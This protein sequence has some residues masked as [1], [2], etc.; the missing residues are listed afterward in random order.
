MTAVFKRLIL[1][2]LCALF[3]CAATAAQVPPPTLAA[4]SW[5]LYDQTTSQF[6]VTEKGDERLEPASLTKLM[7][8]YIVFGAL[9]EGKIK[10]DQQVDV[11]EHAWKQEG[12]RMFIKPG[13]PVTVEQLIRGM[14]IQSGN[15]ACVALAE[16]VAGTEEAF[17]HLM[18]E[19]AKRL[20][21]ENTHYTNAN[22]LPDPQLYTTAKDLA[23]LAAAIIRDFP[24][25]YKY[26]SEKSFT[27]NKITQPNRN[28]LL[29]RD[30]TVD[31]MKTGHTNS[32]GYCL[33]AS[34]NR[35]NHRMISV[36][37]G[38]SSENVRAQES[39]K[40]LNYGFQFYEAAK[41]YDAEQVLARFQ[42]WKGATNEVAAGFEKPLILALPKGE[43]GK[44][45]P[46][47]TSVQP[48]LAPIRKGQE[49]GTLTLSLDGKDIGSWPVVALNE[50]ELAG[51]FGR[52]WDSL[53]MWFKS[54]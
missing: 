18:N 31:G 43:A 46:R 44:L 49:I 40:L 32:A 39:L 34:A 28:L 33:V 27:Y 53:I 52:T 14:I 24:E 42:V 13:M 45:Q 48:V 19:S 11:S 22:G 6:L 37:L 23:K 7:T 12:S 20:G 9:K 41:V 3:S 51:W 30:A 2:T 26:Y 54:L 16:L 38:S 10:L 35:N 5:V 17:V 1:A 50:V 8:A 47:L 25:G 4:K 15:D 21:L 36:L 29:W